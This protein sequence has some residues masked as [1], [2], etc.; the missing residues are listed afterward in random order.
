MAKI[1]GLKVEYFDY[2]VHLS[3]LLPYKYN[4]VSFARFVKLCFC[5]ISTQGILFVHYKMTVKKKMSDIFKTH[6]QRS[7]GVSAKL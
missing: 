6:A 2:H 7:E 1:F 5:K 4:S 3:V